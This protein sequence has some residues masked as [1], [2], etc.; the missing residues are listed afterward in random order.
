[1]FLRAI[2]AAALAYVLISIGSAAHWTGMGRQPE[3]HARGWSSVNEALASTPAPNPPTSPQTRANGAPQPSAV[4]PPAPANPAVAAPVDSFAAERD[5]LMNVVLEKIA[6]RENTPA[7]SVF[8]DIRVLK[9][10]PAMRLVRIMN[11]GYGRSLGVGCKHCHVV[12][13]WEEEDKPQKQVARDMWSMMNTI[14]SELLPK[15]KN[16]KS[17]HPAVNCTT[18]H[19][20]ATKPALNL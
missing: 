8:K 16:L 13:H 10:M 11:M 6:G 14:N 5:S 20:G 4:T 7:E 9:G 2:G 12:G 15:I 19:R 3:S 17:D 18:C 1:M